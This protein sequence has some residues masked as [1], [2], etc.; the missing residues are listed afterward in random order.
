[1]TDNTS[2]SDRIKEELEAIRGNNGGM[3]HTSLIVD[4]ARNHTE[5]A[6]HTQFEWND[7]KAADE[8]RIW[9]ARRLVAIYVDR[10]SGERKLVS[11]T[12]DRSNGGGYRHIDDVVRAPDLREILLRDALAELERVRM[13]YLHV[14]ELADVWAAIERRTT[15]GRKG[16]EAA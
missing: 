3:L 15:K 4:W 12:I 5:S 11:L 16:K 7:A 13:K 10:E 8:Y 1:M 14:K 9:Q 6:L 2:L